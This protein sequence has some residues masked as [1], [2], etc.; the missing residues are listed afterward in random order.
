MSIEVIEE[1]REVH[2]LSASL[3]EHDFES[4]GGASGRDGFRLTVPSSEKKPLP[5]SVGV[6]GVVVGKVVVSRNSSEDEEAGGEI[7]GSSVLP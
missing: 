7:G 4:V 6:S 3:S 2:C 1:R 5:C